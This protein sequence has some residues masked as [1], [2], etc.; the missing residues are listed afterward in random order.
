[1][2]C[3]NCQTYLSDD[4]SFCT[5]CG[6]EIALPEEQ[7]TVLRAR[8]ETSRKF[9]DRQSHAKT[10]EDG[11]TAFTRQLTKSD[12]DFREQRGADNGLSVCVCH[13]VVS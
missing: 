6:K 13:A 2:Y 3:P 10:A 12:I 11:R 8:N 7:E 9:S 4:Y 1:M 5:N